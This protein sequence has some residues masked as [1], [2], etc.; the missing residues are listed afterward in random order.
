VIVL[1][2]GGTRSGKSEVGERIAAGLGDPVTVVVPAASSGDGA[3]RARRRGRRRPVETVA[4]VD[5]D[6]AARIA[7]HRARRPPAW[8]T[9][10]CGTDLVGALDAATG[11]VLVDSL[12]TWVAGSAPSTDR[13]DAVVAALQAR[14]APTVVVTEEVGLAVHPLT[15]AGRHFVD[16][17]GETNARVARVADEVLLVVAGRTLRLDP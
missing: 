17:L 8:T 9:I 6:H 7:V 12:G 14:A 1:V 4:T 16:A 5:A 13:A 10:E 15:E 11:T 3:R 2:I